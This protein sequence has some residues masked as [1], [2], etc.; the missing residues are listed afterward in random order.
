MFEF[1]VEVRDITLAR[2]GQILPEDL[3]LTVSELFNNVGSW[4]LVLANGHPMVPVLR[5]P[6]AG[7]IITRVDTGAVLTSGPVDSPTLDVSATSPGG[8][9]TFTGV[10]DSVILSDR[11]AYP[12]P[13]TPNAAAQSVANDTRTGTAEDLMYAYVD[14][15][16]GPSAMA[17]NFL[18]GDNALF[19][20][21]N[22]TWISVANATHAVVTTPVHTG[23]GAMSVTS[24][25][26]TGLPV[27]VGHVAS[28]SITTAGMP[29]APGDQI[30]PK[31]W[32]RAATTARAV[33]AGAEFFTSA[34]TS[35]GIVLAPSVTNS[36][37]AYVQSA[38]VVTAPTGAAYCRLIV[39]IAGTAN[40]EVHY[41]DDAGLRNGYGRRD[42]RITLGT[43]GHRGATLTKAPRFQVLGALLDEIG[44]GADYPTGTG[45]QLGFRVVQAGS[46]LQFQT[47]PT[48]DHS[49]AVRFD[50]DNGTLASSKVA[51]AA[52]TVT[53]AI[54]A[55]GGDGT[56]RVVVEVDSTAGL[57]AE[58]AW[59]RRIEDFIDQRQTSD[60]DQLT[61]A[62][63][64]AL[65]AGGLSQYSMQITPAD[66]TTWVY[67]VDY[68]LGDTVTVV[69]RTGGT[70]AL[71]ATELAT[72]VTGWVLKADSSGYRF[73]ATLGQPAG[74][75]LAEFSSRLSN[76]E[77]ADTGGGRVI[78]LPDNGFVESEP[79]TSYPVGVSMMG[80][81]TGSG[82]S[83]NSGYG[84]VVTY[85]LNTSRAYQIFH[86]NSVN[87]MWTR[88]YYTSTW[89]PW[90]QMTT[91]NPLMSG[92]VKIFAGSA[93]PSGW[94]A[95]DGSAISRT[96]YAALFAVIGTTYG[97][98][99][100]STTFNVPN[101]NG[102][103]AA[104]LDSAQTE[105]ATLGKSGGEKT[106]TLTG[107]EMPQ[108]Q[109]TI[110]VDTTNGYAVNTPQS[111]TKG[112][113]SY[114]AGTASDRVGTQTAST[115]IGQTGG[116]TAHNN[117][118]PY[119]TL[120]YIIKL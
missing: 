111:F 65:A 14:Q 72:M 88:Y 9:V 22:G 112:A 49:A 64:D 92:E 35:L 85:Y 60:I 73:G 17:P 115:F 75:Q 76:L 81:N 82:W 79:L 41:V 21:S 13:T 51:T 12:D 109:H 59:G 37:T 5:T 95:C 7:I 62:G 18:T 16:I 29:C 2:V 98:G 108:H 99:D 80:L 101:L 71:G 67:G 104:G 107:S 28:A 30:I 57:A 32:T 63:N 113:S 61:Q 117:L 4:T 106:H 26:T 94:H 25:T 23:T 19:D 3:N 110:S 45:R 90:A 24:T 43:N 58:T 86:A 6:G 42:T 78:Q 55:G 31:V 40:G 20:A 84:E 34:G 48:N 39:S 69:I 36:T 54:V 53:R 91:D 33:S 118:Q 120:L 105:F 46:A 93:V 89:S 96:T 8:T 70:N 38:G 87:A 50:V 116:G 114:V 83:V 10:T 68:S 56:D 103:V 66:D 1:T 15:N 77:T 44:T 100:G 97:A 52:P 102:K 27:Q 119:L 11:L 47:Y 74:D